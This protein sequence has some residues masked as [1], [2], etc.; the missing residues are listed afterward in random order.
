MSAVGGMVAPPL[1]IHASCK[2]DSEFPRRVLHIEIASQPE[3]VA[4][5]R[6]AIVSSI[7]QSWRRL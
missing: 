4:G 1:M 3:L 7:G 6:L 5:L 2:S